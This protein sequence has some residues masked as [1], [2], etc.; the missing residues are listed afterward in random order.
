MGSSKKQPLSSPG[1]TQ[2]EVRAAKAE[3]AL[4]EIKKDFDVYREEKC[5]HEKMLDEALETARAELTE[6]RNKVIKFTANEEWNT[7]RF[8][9]AQDNNASYKK[10]I[11]FL[12]EKSSSLSNIVAKHEQSIQVN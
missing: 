1:S 12:E 7:E 3:A 8:K 9:I 10:E 6:A 2:A 11:S 4:E 5:N